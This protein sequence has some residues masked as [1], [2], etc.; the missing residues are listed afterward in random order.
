MCSIDIESSPRLM[1]GGFLTT[2]HNEITITK[3]VPFTLYNVTL[4][5]V[6]HENDKHLQIS[7]LE[8]GKFYYPLKVN[9]IEYFLQ[10]N[11]VWMNYQSKST[12]DL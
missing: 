5:S 12:S 8:T 3:L 11:P 1:S 7:T 9:M 10:M 2:K 4:S 6:V